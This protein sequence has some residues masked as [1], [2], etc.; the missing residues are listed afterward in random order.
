M[1]IYQLTQLGHRL[2]RNT[3]NPD[4]ANWRVLHEMDKLDYATTD[5]LV[6]ATGL[7]ENE[8]AGAVV[9]LRR[10]KLLQER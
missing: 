8:V 10:K 3:N 9:L 4:T 6:I 7:E 1:R 2:A 5:Q